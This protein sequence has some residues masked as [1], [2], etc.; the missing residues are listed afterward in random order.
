[1]LDLSNKNLNVYVVAP[2]YM[3]TGGPELLHQ[4]A[5]KLKAS[6]RN[7]MMHYLPAA[8]NPVHENYVSYNIGYSENIEDSVNNIIVVPETQTAFLK[9]FSRAK[10]IIWWLSVDNYFFVLPLLKRRFN[11]VLLNTFGSQNYFFFD[12]SLK[13]NCYHLV[14]S[15][16]AEVFLKKYDVK[17]ISTMSDYLHQSFFENSTDKSGK[18]DIVVYNPKKG[19]EF[20][21]K[22][23]DAAP[24]I[25]FI[26][27]VNM[28]REQV[29]QLLQKAKVYI[30]FG[31]HP[32][33][34][35]IPREAAYL[36][37]CVITNRRGSALY[38]EDVPIM[39][40]FKFDEKTSDISKII[41]KINDC[42]VRYELNVVKFDSYKEEVKGQEERFEL[43]LKDVFG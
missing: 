13:D 12:K 20:S 36:E 24:S 18:K 9:K 34:D 32:G 26:P 31:F 6:G 3:A 33:K 35:R 16:Y 39:D 5:C 38:K 42:F 25:K 1:M 30:D 8:R 19:I 40:E 22:L 4:F 10:K 21:K 28:T 11:K 7:V 15:K 27:I 43:Q 14:Q 41:S 37:C 29:I 23:M 17:N 2:A